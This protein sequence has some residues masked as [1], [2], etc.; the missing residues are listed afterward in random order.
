MQQFPPAART[1]RGRLQTAQTR[2]VAR[3]S[4][5]LPVRAQ[6]ILGES[7]VDPTVRDLDRAVVSERPLNRRGRAISKPGFPLALRGHALRVP[8]VLARLTCVPG[9]ARPRTT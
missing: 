1:I 5:E 9:V 2:V 7:V 3:R 8:A 4:S 6:P